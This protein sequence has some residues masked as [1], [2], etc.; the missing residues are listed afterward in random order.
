V[1]PAALFEHETAGLRGDD[2]IAP[3]ADDLYDD[4]FT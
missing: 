4:A 1:L 2:S 3:A